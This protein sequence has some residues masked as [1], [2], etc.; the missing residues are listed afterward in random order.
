MGWSWTNDFAGTTSTI[1]AMLFVQAESFGLHDNHHSGASD[2]LHL[3]IRELA[4]TVALADIVDGS[5]WLGLTTKI[6]G[7]RSIMTCLEHCAS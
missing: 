6:G 3:V 4:P 7:L 1:T 5:I 2:P